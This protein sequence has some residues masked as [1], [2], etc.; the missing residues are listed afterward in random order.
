MMLVTLPTQNKHKINAQS[1]RP[2][3]FSEKGLD[4][5]YHERFFS[6]N[7]R[8]PYF[9]GVVSVRVIFREKSG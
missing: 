8:L 3:A 7:S 1:K 5:N 6:V 4:E 2:F 9:I